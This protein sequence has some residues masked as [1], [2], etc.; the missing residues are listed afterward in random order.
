MVI[1]YVHCLRKPGVKFDEATAC[2]NDHASASPLVNI[3]IGVMRVLSK[4][5]SSGS[6]CDWW[7]NKCHAVTLPSQSWKETLLRMCGVT[8]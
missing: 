2:L 7:T 3:P 5:N 6:S 4:D 8:Y 1:L